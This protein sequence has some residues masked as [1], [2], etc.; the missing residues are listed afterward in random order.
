MGTLPEGK[1]KEYSLISG[2]VTN[3]DT[4][5]ESILTSNLGSKDFLALK[6]SLNYKEKRK[7]NLFTM[8]RQLGMPTSFI[9]LFVAIEQLW[10]KLIDSLVALNPVQISFNKS[11]ATYKQWLVCKDLIT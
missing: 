10:S 6:T 2:H 1:L 4:N 7:K 8:I 3:K 9:N 11:I 5:I